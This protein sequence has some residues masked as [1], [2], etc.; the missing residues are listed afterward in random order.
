MALRT[1]SLD[2]AL[3]A[4]DGQ[5]AALRASGPVGDAIERLRADAAALRFHLRDASKRVPMVVV[6]G[7][8][9]TGKSTLI[10]RLVGADV[11]AASYR[12][13]FTAGAI[14]V[15][16]GPENVPPD[17]LALSRTIADTLPAR[18]VAD[19]LVVIAHP[20]DIT[21]RATLVDTPDLDGDQPLHHAQAD[22]A[23]RWA[24]ALV[25]LVTPEK[26]QM[27]ELVPYY[28]LA[29]RY[30]VPTIFVMNKAE[31]L[32]VVEDYR[33]R[34]NDADKSLVYAIP[35]DDANFEPPPEVNLDALRGAIGSIPRND[36][37]SRP[38]GLKNRAADLLDR[39]HD[40]ILAPLAADRSEAE[41]A[42]GMLRA[43]ETPPAG[44][45]VNPITRSLS[46]RLQQRSILY[47]IGPGRVI[48]RVRQ[49]PALLARLPR[50][51]WDLVTRGRADLGQPGDE[52]FDPN[53]APD[54]PSILADQMKV[55]Q[56]RIDDVIRQSAGGTRWIA[57][58][59]TGY[60][61]A[62]VDSKQAAAIAE[63]ELAQL[64][65]WLE[66]RWNATPRDTAIL[67]KVLKHVPGA[68]KLTQWSEA[69][70]YLLTIV[71]AT[72]GALFGHLDLLI[73]GGYSLATWLSER[74]SN[75]VASRTRQANRSIAER[76]ESLAHEQ[77]EG[78]VKWLEAR[79]PSPA[80]LEKIRRTGESLMGSV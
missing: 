19:Q 49:A 53:Q 43:M 6:L 68:Q 14:A 76:F 27:T 41:R 58:D 11:T 45:D 22:R 29:K 25:M 31:Q 3:A 9:G 24:D 66:T 72:H 13:T 10:N 80:V 47:L 71:V 42:I 77:I 40:Q 12:R 35:R 57:E 44:V 1:S 51:A 38:D 17:W 15:A 78:A 65:T 16:A 55:L 20:S 7:G 4:L 23:F 50:T 60:R 69:A 33:A 39:L 28:R 52:P 62:M 73:L 48:D 21:N 37:A 61:S 63:N 26:Y 36:A 67:Q 30:G 59:E 5:V 34:L 64:K 54:F 74:V 2:A 79:A 70:P 8:T 56:S 32:A 46:R 18:G 75:E